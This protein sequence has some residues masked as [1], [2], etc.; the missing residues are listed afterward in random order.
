MTQKD[1]IK[2]LRECEAGCAMGISSIDEIM[3]K[4]HDDNYVKIL[5]ESKA[6]HDKLKNE[7]HTLLTQA[8]SEDKEPSLMAESMASLKTMFKMQMNESDQTAADL[9]VSGCQMGI[10]SLHKYKNK[11]ENAGHTATDICNRL[12]DI[13]DE[14][15]HKSYTYL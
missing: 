2:L 5:Q 9:I 10:R 3:D 11:Y 6:H 8:G 15:C 1:S 13:E 12:L 7:I 14:L 4:V